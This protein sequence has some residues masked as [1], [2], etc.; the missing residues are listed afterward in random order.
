M[1]N[2]LQAAFKKCDKNGDGCLDAD[3]AADAI[4]E[5]TEPGLR[6]A[7]ESMIGALSPYMDDDD[8]GTISRGEFIIAMKKILT[9]WEWEKMSTLR[10]T[11]RKWDKNKSQ[12]ITFEEMVEECMKMQKEANQM[13]V[14]KVLEEADA[15]NDGKVEFEEFKNAFEKAQSREAMLNTAAAGNAN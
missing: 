1:G 3:E 10:K 5:M 14:K 7:T 11:F 13:N 8:D 15:N 9:V 2:D 4:W 12:Q 6:K